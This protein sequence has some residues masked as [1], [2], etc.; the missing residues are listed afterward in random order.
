VQPGAEALEAAGEY[1]ST[2]GVSPTLLELEGPVPGAILETAA[3]RGVDL[4]LIGGYGH[5][6]ILDVVIGST[7]DEVLRWADRPVLICR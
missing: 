5:S 4:L 2:Q 7:V 1:L 6:P 3:E